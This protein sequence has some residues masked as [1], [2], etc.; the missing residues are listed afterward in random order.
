MASGVAACATAFLPGALGK[1]KLPATPLGADSHLSACGSKAA[2]MK[3]Q[4]CEA[5]KFLNEPPG[6]IVVE[7]L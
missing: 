5:L 3:L 2:H 4:G 1:G 6:F 7:L